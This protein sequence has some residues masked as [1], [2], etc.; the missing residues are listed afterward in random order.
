MLLRFHQ[1]LNQLVRL[2]RAPVACTEDLLPDDPVTVHHKR[3]W[4]RAGTIGQHHPKVGIVQ[5]EK[6]LLTE[7]GY[8][9]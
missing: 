3:H 1:Q 7:Y 9:H 6:L 5:D 8:K 4:Q 2:R